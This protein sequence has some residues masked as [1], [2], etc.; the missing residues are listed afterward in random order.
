LDSAWEPE[1]PEPYIQETNQAAGLPAAQPADDGCWA[2]R[3][4]SGTLDGAAPMRRPLAAVRPR[5]I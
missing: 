2:G 3:R 4:A 5:L 1:A